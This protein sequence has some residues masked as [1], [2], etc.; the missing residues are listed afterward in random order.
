MKKLVCLVVTLIISLLSVSLICCNKNDSASSPTY[1]VPSL[2]LRNDTYTTYV[3]NGIVLSYFVDLKAENISTD[4]E[5]EGFG[6]TVTPEDPSIAKMKGMFLSALK[7]GSTKVELSYN[8]KESTITFN[9]IPIIRYL[10]NEAKANENK[11]ASYELYVAC[12]CFI[13]GVEQFKNPSSVQV[14]EVFKHQTEDGTVD[15]YMMQCRAQNSYGGYTTNW[16]IVDYSGISEG[17]QPFIAPGLNLDG[18]APIVSSS[19]DAKIITLA[20]KEY[21]AG[22][23]Y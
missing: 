22:E 21:L 19:G 10:K 15:Y 3:G 1:S 14:L 7:I 4:N 17:F 5:E 16:F 9:V 23:H 6:I 18:F 20:V 12:S 11:G 13:N 8:N 2:T